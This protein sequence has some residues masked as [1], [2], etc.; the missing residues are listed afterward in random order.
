MPL[1][2]AA[3]ITMT[4]FVS[5]G[6]Q[7]PRQQVAVKAPTSIA[8]QAGTYSENGKVVPTGNSNCQRHPGVTATALAIDIA[9]SDY[10]YGDNPP[11]PNADTD[12]TTRELARAAIA[13]GAVAQSPADL[14]TRVN[15]RALALG[16]DYSILATAQ[17]GRNTARCQMFVLR[18]PVAAA[19]IQ[20]IEFR[21]HQN[22]AR[23][24][25]HC[26]DAK[27]IVR[28]MAPKSQAPTSIARQTPVAS[29]ARPAPVASEF[30]LSQVTGGCAIGWSGWQSAMLLEGSG[31][32]VVAAVFKN[33]S[34]N[35]TRTGQLW[36]WHK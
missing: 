26:F 11:C 10:A 14:W 17:S 35:Q 25:P 6:A 16:G 32:T 18:V 28:S 29:A 3:I 24:N 27:R 5:A 2:T 4:W 9:P 31:G 34:H 21:A 20:S 33:W 22:N 36:V 13:E 8:C 19:T 1:K 15:R 12:A 7:A 23:D 30:P